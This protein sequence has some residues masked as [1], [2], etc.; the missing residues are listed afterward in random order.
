MPAGRLLRFCA[1][2]L[3]LV[4]V[5]ACEMP[6]ADAPPGV[7]P[8]ARPDRPAEAPAPPPAPSERS[9]ELASYYARLERDLVGQGLLRTDDG[10]TDAPFTDTQLARNFE[11][12]ALAE[13]YERGAGLRPSAGALGR[14]KR[15]DQ[16]VRVEAMFGASVGADQVRRETGT[17][18]RYVERMARVTDHSISMSDRDPNF[19]VMF[20]SEDDR[21]DIGDRVRAIVPGIDPASLAVLETLPREIH[22]LVIAFSDSPGSYDYGRAIAL[23]RAEHPELLMKSCIHEEVAQGLGLANDSPRARPSIFNDDDEFALLTPHDEMLLRILYDPRLEVGMTAEEAM[24][25]VRDIA[26]DLVAERPS[27]AAGPS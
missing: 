2:A 8:R 22:C 15:W 6:E 3:S 12:I 10:G 7:K 11:R 4:A 21:A 27:V 26:A 16:P 1:A 9:A 25:I 14:I 23:V 19:H 20:L 17:L 5:A 18:S 13:E 24:P